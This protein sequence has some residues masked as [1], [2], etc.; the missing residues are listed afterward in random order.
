MS[1]E[2]CYVARNTLLP[3]THWEHDSPWLGSELEVPERPDG[4][5]DNAQ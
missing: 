3:R 4:E 1:L 5:V 2:H